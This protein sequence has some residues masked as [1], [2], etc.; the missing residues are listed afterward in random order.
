GLVFLSGISIVL[1][2]E[3]FLPTIRATYNN[4]Q[5]ILPFSIIVVEINLVEFFQNKASLLLLIGLLFNLG[6]SWIPDSV[7][8][9]DLTML[10][11]ALI[12]S[13]SIAKNC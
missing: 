8:I 2:A 1:L 13:L 12:M 6:F 7:L 3:H 4:V 5:Y 10:L 9:G 11:Y